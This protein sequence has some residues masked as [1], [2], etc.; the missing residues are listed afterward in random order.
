MNA[1]DIP[2]DPSEKAGTEIHYPCPHCDYDGPHLILAESEDL[3]EVRC[4][5]EACPKREF[6]IHT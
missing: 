1:G 2:V 4:G 6:E 3:I 5:N